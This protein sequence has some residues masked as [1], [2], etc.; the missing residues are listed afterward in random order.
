MAPVGLAADG[1]PGKPD[2]KAW[3]VKESMLY[4][5]VSRSHYLIELATAS[6]TSQ[7][8]RDFAFMDQNT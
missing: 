3:G 5:I 7:F 6:L 2:S 1:D 8:I 4:L